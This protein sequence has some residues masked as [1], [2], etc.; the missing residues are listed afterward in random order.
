[1]THSSFPR[2]G[3][4][5]R[6]LARIVHANRRRAAIAE[7]HALPDRILADIGVPRSQIPYMVDEHLRARKARVVTELPR[8]DAVTVR[9]DRGEDDLRPAA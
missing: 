3:L 6:T 8:D 4:L 5:G 1:M 7:L 2:R 9:G